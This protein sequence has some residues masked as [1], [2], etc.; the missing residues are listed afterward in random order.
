MEL[1]V[2]GKALVIIKG[3]GSGPTTAGDALYLTDHIPTVLGFQM[4]DPGLSAIAVQHHHQPWFA[5][6]S[7]HDVTL[8]VSCLLAVLGL[9]W[10]LLDPASLKDIAP[11]S[12]AVASFALSEGMP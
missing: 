4:P 1:I 12:P 7:Q 2:G 5:V 10:P 6:L 11:P 9:L 8:Q 3:N